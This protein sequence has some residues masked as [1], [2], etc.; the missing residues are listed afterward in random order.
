MFVPITTESTEIITRVDSECEGH[1][2][3]DTVF[4]CYRNVTFPR[5]G[6]LV[7]GCG[8]VRLPMR[9]GFYCGNIESKQFG[10]AIGKRTTAQIECPY[11]IENIRA[12]PATEDDELR[13]DHGCGVPHTRIGPRTIDHNA[14]PLSGFWSAKLRSAGV[15][16]DIKHP[17]CRD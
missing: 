2:H 3:N 9:L 6:P 4:G 5:K 17:T 15:G 12:V 16:L 10:A 8:F 13:T 11:I 7:S 1:K 14:G